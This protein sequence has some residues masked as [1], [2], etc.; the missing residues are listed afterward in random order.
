PAGVEVKADA[1]NASRAFP[2]WQEAYK[3]SLSKTAD[4]NIAK[5]V[6]EYGVGGNRIPDKKGTKLYEKYAGWFKDK[7]N[8]A[9]PA[10]RPR[11]EALAAEARYMGSGMTRGDKDALDQARAAAEKNGLTDEA[12]RMRWLH[13]RES[14]EMELK[15]VEDRVRK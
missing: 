7:A 4:P 1:D 12:E 10:D 5:F 11:W 6:L 2:L 15:R 8:T 3:Q 13:T 9:P 14:F